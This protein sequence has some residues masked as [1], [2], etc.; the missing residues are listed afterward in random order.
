VKVVF[1]QSLSKLLKKLRAL[2]DDTGMLL[3]LMEIH[4][5][6]RAYRA[7]VLPRKQA[8]IE[9]KDLMTTAKKAIAGGY[10]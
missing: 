2:C 1:Y 3:I 10:H 6:L 7:Y 9:G 4:R 8:G 5:V